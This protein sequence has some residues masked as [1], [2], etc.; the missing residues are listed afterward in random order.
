MTVLK[1]SLEITY[2]IA[3]I[4][5]TAL[6]VYYAYKTYKFQSEKSCKLL[7]KMSILKETLGGFE[8]RYALEVYNYGNLVAEKVK[9]IIKGK[10]ITIADFIKPNESFVYPLGKIRQ[11]MGGNHVLPDQGGALQQGESLIVQLEINEDTHN[12]E[13]NTDL[14]YAYRGVANGTLKDVSNA[15]R[16]NQVNW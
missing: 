4:F 9:I 15:I 12:Y 5:L 8:F 7:C 2:Y 16:S 3:F 13:V 14:L 10:C 6:I 11:T 1:D